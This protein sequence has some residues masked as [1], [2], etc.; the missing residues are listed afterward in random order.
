MKLTA[1]TI[2]NMHQIPFNRP[3]TYDLKDITY[4]IGPNGAGKSTILQAIQLALLGY[5]P[6]YDKTSA[7]IMKHSND[8]KFLEVSVL[9][10]EGTDS[11]VVW[12]RWEKS[13]NSVKSHLK[14]TPVEFDIN[15]VIGDL[16]LPVFNFNEF[17]NMTANKLKEWFI[18]F[19][20]KEQFSIDWKEYLTNELGSR[21]MLLS[22]DLMDLVLNII[23][24]L[25]AGGLKG[26][27]LVK[28][29]N[30]QLKVQQSFNKSALERLQGT[31]NSLIYYQDVEDLDEAAINQRLV[32]LNT[33]Y[34]DL[35]KYNAQQA[36]VTRAQADLARLEMD[37]IDDAAVKS[38]WDSAK[39]ATAAKD[40]AEAAYNKVR[41][42]YNLLATQLT[43]LC[44]VSSDVCPYTKKQCAEIAAIVEATNKK[45]ADIQASMDTLTL[46]IQKQTEL[47]REAKQAEHAATY[48][49]TTLGEKLQLATTL[50]STLESARTPIPTSKTEAEIQQEI[51]DLRSQLVK[52]EANK[53]F[54]KLNDTITKDKYKAENNIEVLKIWINS[55]GANGLQTY[56]MEKPFESLAGELSDYLTAIFDQPISGKFILAEKANS[57]SFGIEH[58][59]ANEFVEFDLLSSGEKCLFTVAMIMCLI[60][61]SSATLKLIL[62]DDMFDHLDDSNAERFFA[63]LANTGIQCIL[64]GV[65]ACNNKDICIEIG[66]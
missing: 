15:P 62:A 40:A 13:G 30:D 48:A 43:T 56:M 51:A 8:G 31:L 2:T 39:V 63:G 41:D 38:A 53:Q 42:E 36:Q 32:D 7:S 17:K 3:T 47:L 50:R 37:N 19:L 16:E 27:D 58:G 57:F 46:K 60:N 65:K 14:T 18:N 24:D 20:P 10:T 49:A 26:V 9:L 4:F 52:L 12:R 6:G 64:A 61:R 44:G 34:T 28:G 66:G 25:E 54:Q 35:V 45:K 1:V 23:S 33:L 59:T 21:S 29:L 22:D 11:Y 55:T 5:I